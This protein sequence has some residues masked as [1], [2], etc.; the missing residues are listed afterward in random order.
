MNYQYRMV[1]SMRVL[2]IE[3][4]RRLAEPVKYIL[5]KNKYAVDIAED[6][7]TGQ[8]MA[9]TGIYDVIILDRLLPGKEGVEVLKSLRAGNIKTPIILVTAK[10][11]VPD[12]IEGLNAGAD[13]YLVKPFANDELLAR[14]G[15][16]TRRFENVAVNL[17]LQLSSL[18][19]DAKRCEVY[20]HGGTIRLSLR[21]SQLLE[22][23]MRNRGQILTKEQLFNKVWG[24]ESETEITAV[25][26]YIFYLRKKIDFTKCGVVLETIRGTGYCLREASL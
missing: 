1:I 21:E 24:F 12:R 8:D 13:D 11:A 17:P 19:L 15:A 25:E 2:L 16:L 6:G 5:E 3:D 20:A 14:V 10:D 7:I 4:E 26:L 23:L 9:E 18:Q 22:C